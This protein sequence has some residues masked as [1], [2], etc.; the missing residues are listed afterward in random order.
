MNVRGAKG[1]FF[2]YK[3]YFFLFDHHLLGGGNENIEY[4][5]V[6]KSSNNS[7]FDGYSGMRVLLQVIA[8][9]TWGA[10]RS[11]FRAPGNRCAIQ[12]VYQT[13]R[14]FFRFFI[15]ILLFFCFMLCVHCRTC[16]CCLE[17]GGRT[18][19]VFSARGAW[20]ARRV[21]ANF[22]TIR[23]IFHCCLCVCMIC[24]GRKWQVLT[25]RPWFMEE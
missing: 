10:R 15:F 11:V 24:S 2:L 19:C 5:H 17:M 7:R 16:D 25:T 20:R 3:M 1:W 13:S 21:Q 12:C 6:V 4:S 18:L 9:W 8:S 22:Q 14:W 23:S